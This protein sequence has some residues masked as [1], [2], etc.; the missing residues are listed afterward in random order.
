MA[1][2]PLRPVGR[3]A[4]CLSVDS[5]DAERQLCALPRIAQESTQ[6]KNKDSTVA[7]SSELRAVNDLTYSYQT[8]DGNM[9]KSCRYHNKLS[10]T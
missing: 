8:V 10:L 1:L 9:H 2:T 6:T 4:S 3:L 7:G 5:G